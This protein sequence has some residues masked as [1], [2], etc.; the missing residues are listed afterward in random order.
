MEMNSM[1]NMIVLKNFPSNI[2][3]E[4]FVVLKENVKIHKVE[5]ADKKGSKEKEKKQMSKQDS[6]VK[7]AEMLISEYVDTLQK[8][9]FKVKNENKKMMEKYQKM[10]KI[11]ILLSIFSVLS[12]IVILLK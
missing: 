5:M 10:K 2:V 4:V 1:K 9:E 7:E 12:T 11:T 6:I 8:K 3:E